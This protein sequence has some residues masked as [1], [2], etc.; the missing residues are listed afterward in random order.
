[1]LAF[2]SLT[3]ACRRININKAN[4]IVKTVDSMNYGQQMADVKPQMS[5]LVINLMVLTRIFKIMS[6]TV[7]LI[8]DYACLKLTAH[9]V[10]TVI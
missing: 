8:A 2:L 4:I 9:M 1:M 5:N 7:G 3:R 10:N 6:Q